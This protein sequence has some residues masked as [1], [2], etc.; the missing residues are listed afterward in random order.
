[1]CESVG[2]VAYANLLGDGVGCEP[3]VWLNCVLN[4][5]VFPENT[6]TENTINFVQPNERGSVDQGD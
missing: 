3:E 2:A 6:I 4:I 1:M 5:F